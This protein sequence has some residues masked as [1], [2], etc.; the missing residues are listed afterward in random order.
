[1]DFQEAESKYFEL[2]GRLNSG[3][4]TEEQFQAE[5]ARLRI[6]DDEGRYWTVDARSGGWLLYDGTRWVPAQP[7]GSAAAPP[8]PPSAAPSGRKGGSS[9][10]FL[11]GAL[12]VAAV[13]CLVALGG[14]VILL[15]R[16]GGADGTAAEPAAVTQ[17]QAER[18]A[19]DLVIKEFPEMKGA[20]KTLG[21]FQNP[22][23]TRFWTVTYRQDVQAELEGVSYR[24]PNVVIVS[25]DQETGEPVVAVS[26]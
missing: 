21:S 10:V 14:A 15:S 20:E 4:L 1:M 2:K 23:G 12:A 24:I 17:G 26:G 6:H 3:R 5:V 22:A 19:D 25:V 16:T 18:I 13:L 9:P 11:V 7:P 8:P